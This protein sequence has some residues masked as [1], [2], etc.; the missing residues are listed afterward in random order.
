MRTRDLDEI[1]EAVARVY[2]PHRVEV[3]GSQIHAALKVV[4]P[5]HQLLV[6]LSYGAPVQ[7]DAYDFPRLFLMMHC[8]QGAAQTIQGGLEAEWSRGRTLPFSAGLETRLRFDQAFVQRSIRLDVDALEE[9]CSR[10]LGRP[11]DQPLRF[12]LRPF[13]PAFERTWQQAVAYVASFDRSAGPMA[14]A[15]TASLDEHLL[16]ILLHHHPHNYSEELAAPE[17]TPVPGLVRRAE[18]YMAEHSAEPITMSDVAAA[19]GVSMRSLQQGFRQWRST[20]PRSYLRRLRLDH[21]RAEFQRTDVRVSVTE[22]ALRHGFSHLGR[23]SAY[24]RD[25]FGELPGATLRRA[26][27]PAARGLPR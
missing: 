19:L 21:V 16:T 8:A 13:S 23:F 27:G 20:T 24:Y 12:A 7:I 4:T 15:A 17:P 14:L 11:V 25:T 3:V 1:T 18:R 26:Q 9:L 6:E 10:W 5:T 2:C 22:V